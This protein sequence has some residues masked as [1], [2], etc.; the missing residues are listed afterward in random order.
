MLT[1]LIGSFPVGY[2]EEENVTEGAEMGI[3]DVTEGI[4]PEPQ[5]DLEAGTASEVEQESHP[6]AESVPET[7]QESESEA[8][9][10]P[11]PEAEPEQESEPEMEQD[12]APERAYRRETNLLRLK[13]F[14]RKL[15]GTLNY[16]TPYQ[17]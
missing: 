17:S 10:E 1:M 15:T 3:P 14:F 16:H 2:S 4:E 8:D 7:A 5:I 11:E 12:P 6:A 13:L 9:Q